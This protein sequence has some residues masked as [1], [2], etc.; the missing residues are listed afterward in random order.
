MD[1][2]KLLKD[3]STLCNKYTGELTWHQYVFGTIANLV[4]MKMEDREMT[5]VQVKTKRMSI[6]RTETSC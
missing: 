6:H 5:V 1:A 2:N 4:E 3:Y